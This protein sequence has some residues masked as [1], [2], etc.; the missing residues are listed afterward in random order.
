MKI[1]STNTCFYST[2][3]GGGKGKV[4]KTDEL[5]AETTIENLPVQL[6][7]YFIK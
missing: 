7:Q 3:S 1:Y 2:G 6:P 4:G 5:S